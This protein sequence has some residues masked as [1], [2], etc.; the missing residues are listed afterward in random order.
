MGEVKITLIG[1]PAALI[2]VGGFRLL[3]DPVFDRNGGSAQHASEQHRRRRRAS[4]QPRPA[5]PDNVAR[6]SRAMLAHAA[7]VLTTVAGATLLGAEAEGLE[8]WESREL[9]KPDG[10]RIRI[11]ATP[12]REGRAGDRALRRRCDRLCHHLAHRRLPAR[13][14][15]RRSDLVRWRRRSAA[16]LS[17]PSCPAPCGR[18]PGAA[19][20]C[21]RNAAKANQTASQAFM[22]PSHL[23]SWAY[24]PQQSDDLRRRNAPACLRRGASQ[25]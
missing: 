14:Y 5:R 6:A 24:L 21:H 12:A 8:P 4:A 9:Y 22:A 2:E 23:N 25:T 20:Q 1:G 18:G 16:A 10:S 19:V 13:L 7:W 11:T 15:H 3:I 17:A